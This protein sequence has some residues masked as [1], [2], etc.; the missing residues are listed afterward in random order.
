MFLSLSRIEELCLG[1]WIIQ[2]AER[3]DPDLYVHVYLI[4]IVMWLV[5]IV[6]RQLK[7]EVD[8]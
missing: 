7:G 1:V 4:V 6:V 8:V 3:C 5:M 2:I